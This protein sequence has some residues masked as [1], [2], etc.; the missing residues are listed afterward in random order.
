MPIDTTDTATHILISP[1]YT[2]SGLDHWQTH[3]ERSAPRASRVQ[4]VSWDDVDHAAWVEGV[5]AALDNI[6]TSERIRVVAHSCGAVAVAQWACERPVDPRVD[7]LVLV[8]PA[9]VDNPVHLPQIASQA[10]LPRQVIPYPVVLVSSD[11]DPHLSSS[12]AGELAQMWQVEAHH[13]IENG[14][15]LATDD[16]Y[17]RWPWMEKLLAD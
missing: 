16:G 4:Q 10:P 11:N 14:G 7:K 5:Q 9:D 13:V 3:L 1:G 12:R 2:N 17:G 6:G 15:H 8:A